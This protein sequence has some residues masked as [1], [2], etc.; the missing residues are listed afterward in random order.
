LSLTPVCSAAVL[1]AA[2][3]FNFLDWPSYVRL[4]KIRV[5]VLFIDIIQSQLA[6]Q[7]DIVLSE[8]RSSFNHEG[9]PQ[10]LIA[11]FVEVRRHME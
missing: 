5:L 4:L 10:R 2:G 9:L 6:K 11:R 7:A 1:S 8:V 3:S